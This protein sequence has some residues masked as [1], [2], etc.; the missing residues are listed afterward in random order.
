[1]HV[2]QIRPGLLLRGQMRVGRFAKTGRPK[3]KSNK[4]FKRLETRAGDLDGRCPQCYLLYPADCTPGRCMARVN[5]W[6][7]LYAIRRMMQ[8]MNENEGYQEKRAAKDEKDNA[9]RREKR[10]R[11]RAE[12]EATALPS[13]V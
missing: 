1:M 10:A 2:Q 6:E 3:G 7:Q 8:A 5:V 11:E 4:D 13:D 12:R 9:A